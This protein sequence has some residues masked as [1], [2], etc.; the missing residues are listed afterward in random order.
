M[1]SVEISLKNAQIKDSILNIGNNYIQNNGK[2]SFKNIIYLPNMTINPENV[3][4]A[5]QEQDVFLVERSSEQNLENNKD[6]EPSGPIYDIYIRDGQ[7]K[8]GTIENGVITFTP[9]YLQMMM[10]LSPFIYQ[11]LMMQQGKSYEIA[12]GFVDVSR[13]E[14]GIQLNPMEMSKEDI[15]KEMQER[16]GLQ[17][18]EKLTEQDQEPKDEEQ[19]IYELITEKTKEVNKEE[20]EDIEKLLDWEYEYKDLA[21]IPTKTS[22]TKI[23]EISNIEDMNESTRKINIDIEESLPLKVSIT[24]KPKFLN[25]NKEVKI[26]NAQKGTLMHLCIQRMCERQ[27]YDLEKIDELITTLQDKSLI[28]EVEANN[29]NKEKLLE[30]TKSKLWD[31]LKH[32]KEIHKEKPFYINIKASKLYDNISEKDDENILVQGVIDLYFITNDDKLVL[33]DFK[34]DYVK[35]EEELINKYKKQLELYKEA[36]EQALNKKVDKMGL[37]SLYLNRTLEV[38]M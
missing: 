6:T 1:D 36:L 25:E 37:Y 34:T 22:V 17:G 24:E 27:D 18:Q 5:F 30:Y 2:D 38:K 3:Q 20:A 32:A 33:I 35:N 16:V 21:G 26:T 10:E 29:I 13:E 31:M 12:E 14:D 7:I 28:T 11:T 8:M 4:N 19:D 15:E 23:K 9:E